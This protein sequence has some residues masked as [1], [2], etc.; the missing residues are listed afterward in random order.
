MN[1]KKLML[2]HSYFVIHLV[3]LC[4]VGYLLATVNVGQIFTVKTCYYLVI[5]TV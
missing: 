2:L 4:M 5:Y 3:P 1:K